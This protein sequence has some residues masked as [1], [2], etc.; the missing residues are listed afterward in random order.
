V[1]TAVSKRFFR[2]KALENRMDNAVTVLSG[3]LELPKSPMIQSAKFDDLARSVRHHKS[4]GKFVIPIATNCFDYDA[5][6][7]VRNLF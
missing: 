7:H 6:S 4:L 1:P 2:Q 5:R 3:M